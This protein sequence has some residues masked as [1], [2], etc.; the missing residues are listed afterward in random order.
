MGVALGAKKTAA[1]DDLHPS[2]THQKWALFMWVTTVMVLWILGAL[3]YL[4]LPAQAAAQVHHQHQSIAPDP[5]PPFPP[6]FTKLHQFG[7]MADLQPNTG[8]LGFFH[9]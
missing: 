6:L 8:Q 2:E 9:A 4:A 3:F 1:H 5:P 7:L